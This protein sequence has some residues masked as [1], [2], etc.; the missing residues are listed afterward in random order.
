[1]KWDWMIFPGTSLVVRLAFDLLMPALIVLLFRINRF[2][3]GPLLENDKWFP[4]RFRGLWK[5]RMCFF[6][7]WF[8]SATIWHFYS[9]PI[10]RLF[11]SAVLLSTIELVRGKP[12]SKTNLHSYRLSQMPH[13]GARI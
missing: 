8:F 5:Y 9:A 1:M 2:D 10:R 13:P 7:G 3:E 6:Y 11:S 12:M 4:F